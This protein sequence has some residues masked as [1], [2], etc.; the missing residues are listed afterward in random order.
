M[1]KILLIAYTFPPIP[2]GGSFRALRISQGLVEKG[3]ECH[4]LTIK[5]YPDIPNDYGL[6]GKVPSDVRIHRTKIVD[7]WRRYQG[8]KNKYKDKTGFGIVNKIVSLWLR[9]ITFPDHMLLW[10]PFAYIKAYKIIKQHNIEN[11]IVTSPPHSSLFIG[12]LLKKTLKIKW[13]ADLR[14]PIYGNVAQVHL[15]N[16]KSKLDKLEAGLLKRFDNFVTETADVTIANTKHHSEVLKESHPTKEITFIRNSYDPDDYRDSAIEKQDDFIISHVGSIYGKRSPDILF[17]SLRRLIDGAAPKQ[18]KIKVIFV[19]LT[20]T[21]LKD[22]I[23]EYGLESYVEIR[24]MVPHREAINTMCNSN[25]LLLIKATGPWSTGQ[26][27]G[28]FFEYVGTGKRILCLGPEDSEVAALIGDNKLGYVVSEDTEKLDKIV[29]GEYEEFVGNN[30]NVAI[31]DTTK[32]QFS[33]TEMNEKIYR[34]IWPN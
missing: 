28:K 24:E 27:P 8:I 15:I 33:K 14:D 32:K 20:S 23:D 26:I 13:I 29:L 17:S 31:D 5:E 11:V 18:L 21:T 4:V 1:K 12:W 34:L 22:S 3:V 7:P 6:L 25:L 16:P 2:Y 19:G 10:L 30:D 9:T